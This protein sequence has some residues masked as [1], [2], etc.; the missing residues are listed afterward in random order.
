MSKVP[1]EIAVDNA[2]A[3]LSAVRGGAERLELYS[4]LVDGGVTPSIGFAAWAVKA[5]APIPVFCMVR[6][7]A[8]DFCYSADEL[9][10]MERD[11]AALKAVGAAG[12]VLGVLTASGQVDVTATKRLVAATHPMRVVFHRAFDVTADLSQ[13]LEDLIATG[14]DILLTSGG[15]AS[16]EAGAEQVK[17]LVAQA[18]GRIEMMGGAGVR[19]ANAGKLWRELGLDTLHTS[20][21]TLIQVKNEVRI[22][23]RDTATVYTVREEDVRAVLA[24][25]A[26]GN[27]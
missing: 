1:L 7:R 20:L 24:A 15:A 4:S 12:V 21:R 11:I 27:S 22:G 10:V 16:L 13:A 25:M 19:A 6:P 5:A 18:T 23:G 9:D 14:A 8:G 2:D 26:G 17:K 3:V